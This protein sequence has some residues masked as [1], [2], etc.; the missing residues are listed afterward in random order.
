MSEDSRLLPLDQI[1]PGMQ[2]AESVRDRLGNVMLPEGTE[3]AEQHL[4]S[5]EKRGVTAVLIKSSPPPLTAEDRER[6]IRAVEER[7]DRIF[8][9]SIGN[10]LNRQLKERI[11]AY[12]MEQFD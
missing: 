7:L 5:L 3:L 1:Q 6:L 9:L 8:R 10:P 11:L 2:L 4:S 12:R